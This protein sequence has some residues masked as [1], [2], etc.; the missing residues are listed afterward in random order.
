MLAEIDSDLETTLYP[1]LRSLTNMT[2][3]STEEMEHVCNYIYW[4]RLSGVELKFALSEDQYNQ[5]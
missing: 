1:G 3:A 5:C 2:D 4:A